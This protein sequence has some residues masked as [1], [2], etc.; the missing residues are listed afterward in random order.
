MKIEIKCRFSGSV[1]FE[2]DAENNTTRLTV[3]AAVKSGAYLARANLAR[4][5]LA[6]AYLDG[7]NLAGANL[8]GANL[9]GAYLDGAYLDGAKL[10]NDE[11][12]KG[13]RPI[14]QIGPIGSRCSY[15]I[16]YL[17]DKGIRL[18]AG[19]FFGTV[20]EFKKKL[21][22]VH[23]DNKHAKEYAAA[24]KLVKAHADIWMTE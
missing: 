17:T 7:A 24:L 6:G 16:A 5:N 15:F 23:A 18:K 12:L 8:A 19:C 1:L 2:H 9:D 13:K 21:K 10:Q 22:E 4:A 14:I 20:P 11:L 3:E